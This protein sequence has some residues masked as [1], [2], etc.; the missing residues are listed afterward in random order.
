MNI[1][2]EQIQNT[3]F[4]VTEIVQSTKTQIEKN[5][6]S[7]NALLKQKITFDY[8]KLKK[9]I[10]L[11]DKEQKENMLVLTNKNKKLKTL[12]IVSFLIAILSILINVI[13]RN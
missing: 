3:K 5:V 6:S 13:F 2:Y 11:N 4:E 1:K 12:C 10:E 7:D 9:S 8:D